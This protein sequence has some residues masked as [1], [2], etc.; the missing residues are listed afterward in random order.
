MISVLIITKNDGDVIGDC[1]KSVKDL[2]DEIIVVDGG[3]ED[4]TVEISEKLGAKVVRNPFKNFSDQRNLALSLAKGDWVFYIDSDERATPAFI[5]EVKNRI[6]AVGL[7]DSFDRAQDKSAQDKDIGGFRIRRKTFYL[8]K[9][10][11]FT[12]KVER[13]FRKD[14]L[15]GWHGVVHETPEFEGRLETISESILHYTHRNLEQMVV[16]TNEWSEFEA[17]LRSKANHPKMNVFRFFRVMITGFL[18]SYISE[19]GYKNG[20]AGLIESIYQAFSMF[21]TYV[22]LWERIERSEGARL[23]AKRTG[24]GAEK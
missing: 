17:D 10:W 4:N 24:V 16:K 6:R 13:V 1:I 11:G 21:V 22:K 12:D 3:S 15:K 19:K 5:S 7:F 2:A 9:D 18:R 23:Q 8:G 20:T 14:K